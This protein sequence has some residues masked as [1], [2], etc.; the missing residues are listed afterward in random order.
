[1][2]FTRQARILR[3]QTLHPDADPLHGDAALLS[4]F[5]VLCPDLPPVTGALELR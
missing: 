4:S 1:M 5:S 3:L 2:S